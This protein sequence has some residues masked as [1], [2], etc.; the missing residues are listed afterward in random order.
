MFVIIIY[1]DAI[2]NFNFILLIY[3]FLF[4]LKMLLNCNQKYSNDDNYEKAK[5]WKIK[6]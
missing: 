3:Y 6:M 2:L 5:K 1:V 4:K